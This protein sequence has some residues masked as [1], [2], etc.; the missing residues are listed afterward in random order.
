MSACPSVTIHLAGVKKSHDNKV[1][2]DRMLL[3]IAPGEWF[4]LRMVRARA[5]FV[6]GSPHGGKPVLAPARLERMCIGV[7]PEFDDL[8]SRSVRE[9]LLVFGRYFSMRSKVTPSLLELVRLGSEADPRALTA[10]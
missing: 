3:A 4:G 7:V 6:H 1:V 5:R 9:D 8:T 2:L 10:R